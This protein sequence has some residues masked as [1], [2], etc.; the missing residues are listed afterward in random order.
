MDGKPWADPR[1]WPLWEGLSQTLVPPP[2]RTVS[3]SRAVAATEAAMVVAPMVSEWAFDGGQH[4]RG[5]TSA[6]GAGLGG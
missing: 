6:L 2:T 5:W 1:S 4:G 3:T